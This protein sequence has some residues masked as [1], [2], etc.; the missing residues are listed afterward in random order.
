MKRITQEI[1][2]GTEEME[3]RKR[4]KVI[5]FRMGLCANCG[6]ARGDSPYTRICLNCGEEKKRKRRKKLGSR[7]WKPGCPGRPPVLFQKQEEL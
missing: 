6:E 5:R 1:L 3:R 4:W 2:A 7:P